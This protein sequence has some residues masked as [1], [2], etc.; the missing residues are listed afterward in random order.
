MKKVL[1][2]CLIVLFICAVGGAVVVYFLYR[3]AQP[4]IQNVS[5]SIDRAQELSALGEKIANK[6]TYTAPASGELTQAQVDRFLRVQDRVV[7]NLGP[8]W[9]DLEARVKDIQSRTDAGAKELSF[10]EVLTFFAEA[11]SVL[12]EARRA[13]VDALNAEQFSSEEYNWVRVNAYSAAGLELA[14]AIDWSAVQTM[15]QENAAKAGVPAPT[16]PKMEVPEANRALVKPH[17]AKLK[18]WWGLAFLGL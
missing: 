17:V 2:G 16:L 3:A 6:A 9:K 18:E 13:Q 10:T 11:G 7:S 4:M 5:E 14:G 12:V 15:M 8:R 1:A